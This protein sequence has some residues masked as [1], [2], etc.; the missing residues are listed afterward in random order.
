MPAPGWRVGVVASAVRRHSE[1]WERDRVATEH[2]EKDAQGGDSTMSKG[3]GG[4]VPGQQWP[5]RG[6]RPQRHARWSSTKASR[7]GAVEAE[8]VSFK[9]LI[10][11]HN[12]RVCLILL[13]ISINR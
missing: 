3:N 2:T 7:G 11:N 13:E 8:H 12:S 4:R 9:M 1:S 6:R 10:T 5:G